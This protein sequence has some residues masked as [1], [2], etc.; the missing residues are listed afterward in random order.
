MIPV[1]M[2]SFF[3]ILTFSPIAKSEAGL[4]PVRP[5]APPAVPP[6]T[7]PTVPVVPVPVKPP[8]PS[9]KPPT[10]IPP[11]SSTPSSGAIGTPSSGASGAVDPSAAK[12]LSTIPSHKPG[13]QKSGPTGRRA[14]QP[15]LTT[16]E[17]MERIKSEP[18]KKAIKDSPEA[19][20]GIVVRETLLDT[21]LNGQKQLT[22]QS[23]AKFEKALMERLIG[24]DFSKMTEKDLKDLQSLTCGPM[25]GGHEN[26]ALSCRRVSKL[27]E[28]IQNPSNTAVLATAG[29]LGTVFAAFVNA[30][31]DK[32]DGAEEMKVAGDGFFMELKD[33]EKEIPQEKL[34]PEAQA[35]KAASAKE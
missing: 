28:A 8:V 13:T 34:V 10:V 20:E 6:V 7:V 1:T 5:V 22:H 15:K 4:V 26:M 18:L 32:K 33:L 24:K 21:A 27:I 23:A 30:I 35:S 12:R 3:L 2:M 25:C 16:E 19:Q 14:E 11:A 17:V 29:V 31:V 9:A